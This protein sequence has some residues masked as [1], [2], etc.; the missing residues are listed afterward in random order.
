MSGTQDDAGGGSATEDSGMENKPIVY[1]ILTGGVW[2]TR[3][4]AITR[5]FQADG[6]APTITAG[7]GGA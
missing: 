6:V 4:K 2:A 1:G 3:F 7:G 5:V